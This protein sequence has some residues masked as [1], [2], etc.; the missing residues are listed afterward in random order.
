MSGQPPTK[1]RLNAT[2]ASLLGFLLEGP[3]SG[4]DLVRTAQER[5]GDFWS[6]THSQVY[7]ELAA[8]ADADLVE[9]GERGTR[10]RTPY[11]IT[12]S[13]RAA[14]AE[15]AEQEPSVESIRFPLL[16]ALGFGRHV[17]RDRLARWLAHHRKIHADR[18]A[19]YEETTRPSDPY[20]AATLEFGIRYERAVL[21]WFDSLPPDFTDPTGDVVPV[22]R[23]RGA[24]PAAASR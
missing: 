21:E 19:R 12:A 7:R 9:P 5:I 13:G 18:L 17:P 14:F 4:W 16:L 8:M 6:L 11:A 15:W 22:A 2:S 1:H 24:G 23:L 3:K 10:D 20:A